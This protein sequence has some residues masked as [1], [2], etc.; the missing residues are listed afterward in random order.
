MT[1]KSD[2][3]I[4]ALLPKDAGS[5]RKDR[6]VIGTALRVMVGGGLP[7]TSQVE[8]MPVGDKET[9]DGVTWRRFLLGRKGQKEGVPAVSLRGEAF[10]GTVVVWIHPKGKASLLRDGK[11]VPEA[12][13]ILDGK[14]GILAPDVFWTGEA[15]SIVVQLPDE[16]KL[17]AQSLTPARVEQAIKKANV[18]V[19]ALGN[20]AFLLPRENAAA[21]R[22]ALGE[23]VVTVAKGQPVRVRDLGEIT[24]RDTPP[25]N[26]GYAGYTFGYNRPLLANRMQDI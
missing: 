19:I 24:P 13:K 3:Q 16:K 21:V 25:V 1:E 6:R 22:Q 10:D 11:L 18:K 15:K 8:C 12:R 14:A 17:K 26:E 20:Q 5:L 9:H 23:V 7:E 4:A 2:E